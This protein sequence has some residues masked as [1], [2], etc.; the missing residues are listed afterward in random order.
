MGSSFDFKQFSIRQERS[1][2]K[3]GT[4]AVVLGAAMTLLGSERRL[5]DIGTGTGVIAPP[6]VVKWKSPAAARSSPSSF[7][8]T[9]MSLCVRNRL[10]DFRNTK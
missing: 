8:I 6:C 2:L 7:V 3:V 10:Q 1:A 9:H 4:D 5:L